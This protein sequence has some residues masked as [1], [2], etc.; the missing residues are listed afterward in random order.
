MPLFKIQGNTY[1]RD[2]SYNKM[3]PTVY[4]SVEKRVDAEVIA[5]LRF[6]AAIEENEQD[7]YELKSMSEED[8]QR[9]FN[10]DACL[11]ALY[12]AACGK[13]DV[14]ELSKNY[15]DVVYE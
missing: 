2:E 12:D 4:V 7:F 10:S 13:F 6:K 5:T 1:F 9:E 11:K 8:R 14:R 15:T 3:C